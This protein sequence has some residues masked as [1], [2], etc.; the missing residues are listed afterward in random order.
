MVRDLPK[1]HQMILQLNRCKF[2]G[3]LLSVDPGHT[4]GI[5]ILSHTKEMTRLEFAAQ[6]P[7]WPLESGVDK[8]TEVLAA[9]PAVT[10]CVYESYHIYDW[11]LEQHSFAEVPTIQIIG[12]LKTLLIQHKIPYGYQSAQIGKGFCTDRK[13]EVWDL[14]LPGL[15]HARDSLRHGCHYLLF[16]GRDLDSRMGN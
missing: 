14:W 15:V 12:C 16:G 5:N 1:L 6:L 4:S 7:T 10:A 8:F 9:F 2:E 13:L 3:Q 11:K